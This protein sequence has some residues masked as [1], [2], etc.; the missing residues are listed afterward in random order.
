[1]RRLNLPAGHRRS[2]G[3]RR[4]CRLTAEALEQRTLLST[5]FASL[6]DA[7]GL[8]TSS[9]GDVYVSYDDSNLLG[10]QEAIAEFTSSGLEL[11]SA[12]ITV[13][14]TYAFPGALTTLSSSAELPISGTNLYLASGSV[15]ELQPDGEMFDY[16]PATGASVKYFSFNSGSYADSSVY[17]TQTGQYIG[18][19]STISPA[20]TTF[21]EFAVDGGNVLITGESNGWDFVVRATYVELFEVPIWTETV[22]MAAPVPYGAPLGPWGLAVNSQGTVLTSLP[23][24]A[25]NGVL[26]SFNDQNSFAPTA[27]SLGLPVLPAIDAGGISVDADGDF[28]IGAGA[29]SLVEG[30]PGYVAVTPDL[31]QYTR[32]AHHALRQW[33]LGADPRGDRPDAGDQ[34]GGA[35]DPP[36]PGRG[37]QRRVL[38]APD[39]LLAG[40]DPP[41]LW[42]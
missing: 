28:L 26:E 34:R 6:P 30:A 40:S 8:T 19:G 9:S 36:R 32:R 3:P 17:D 23:N 24:A 42:R 33:R 21:G 16:N 38:R 11:N 5:V 37:H 27:P 12:V 22:L 7:T 4:R 15:L 39:E 10:R 41:R 35:G 25:G 18:L 1:M 29:T 2:L 20:T 13:S 31:Q 14:G